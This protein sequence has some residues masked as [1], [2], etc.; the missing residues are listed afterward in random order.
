M[1]IN[2]GGVFDDMFTV[3]G[4]AGFHP[5]KREYTKART[6]K[7]LGIT[8]ECT[9]EETLENQNKTVS[10]KHTNGSR[11][12]VNLKFPRGIANGSKIKYKELGDKKYEDLPIWRFNCYSKNITP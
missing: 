6:N 4:G 9:L 7:N 11:H 5:S 3:F 1:N 12:L 10:I 2:K 8:V